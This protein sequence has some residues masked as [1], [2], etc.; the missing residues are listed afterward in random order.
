[1]RRVGLAKDADMKRLER[2]HDDREVIE[3]ALLGYSQML[4]NSQKGKH[5]RM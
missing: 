1:M 5:F 3:Y 4:I 2:L